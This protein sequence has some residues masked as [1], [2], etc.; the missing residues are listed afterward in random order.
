MP[1][2]AQPG[3][4]VFT[5]RP[6]EQV[7]VV[8][9]SASSHSAGPK[10]GVQPGIIVFVQTFETLQASVVHA[11]AS[12]HSSGVSQQGS[13]SGVWM[14]TPPTHWSSEQAPMS[15]QSVSS[16]QSGTPPS[17]PHMS[18]TTSQV[19]DTQAF[20]VQGTPSSQGR[21]SSAV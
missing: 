15:G 9:G 1:H 6:A 19:P 2:I 5:Q 3:I 11:L 21:A 18:P 13:G 12:S 20:I 16:T 4:A 7:S 10:H 17:L 14:Q 8:Q